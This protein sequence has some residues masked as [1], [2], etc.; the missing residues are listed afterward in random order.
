MNRGCVNEAFYL[1]N[2][3]FD[4]VNTP[5]S[6]GCYLPNRQVYLAA[7]GLTTNFVHQYNTLPH[8]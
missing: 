6:F 4:C 3:A 1:N 2:T 8:V 5:E 7:K